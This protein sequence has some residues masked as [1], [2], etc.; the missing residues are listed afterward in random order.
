MDDN[1]M[2]KIPTIDF[3]VPGLLALAQLGVFAVFTYWGAEDISGNIDYLFPL[4]TATAGL[5]IFL[6][7]P[8]ARIAATA[9]ILG[10]IHVNHGGEYQLPTSNG[11]RQSDIGIG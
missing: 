6:S 3:S 4:M 5:A 1:A 2:Y 11:T 8:N 7:V 9:G 10:H